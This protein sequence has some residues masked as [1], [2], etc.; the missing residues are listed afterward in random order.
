[1]HY[2][3]LN[4]EATHLY[5][6]IYKFDVGQLN[7]SQVKNLFQQIINRELWSEVPESFKVACEVF[8]RYGIC[9]AKN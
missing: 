8:V 7:S 4:G 9:H 1:M 2:I 6:A 3:I 5:Q